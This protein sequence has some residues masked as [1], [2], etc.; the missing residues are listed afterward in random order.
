MLRSS[1]VPVELLQREPVEVR[2]G[3]GVRLR[4]P[5]GDLNSLRL[6]L[7]VVARLSSDSELKVVGRMSSCQEAE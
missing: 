3:N 4:L 6:T 7:E 2:L 1:F 5:A